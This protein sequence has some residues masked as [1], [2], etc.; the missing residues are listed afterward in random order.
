MLNIDLICEIQYSFLSRMLS[1]R[2]DQPVLGAAVGGGNAGGVLFLEHFTQPVASSGWE[3]KKFSQQPSSSSNDSRRL[4]KAETFST[5]G[6]LFLCV[7]LP[8]L[9]ENRIV[10]E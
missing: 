3:E 5:E 7:L 9:A 4:Q 2:S 6:S 1:C 8:K 10:I